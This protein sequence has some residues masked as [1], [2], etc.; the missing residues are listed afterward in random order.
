MNDKLEQLYNLYKQNGIIQSTDFNTFSSADENQKRKLY[1]LGKQ[2]GLFNTTDFNTFNSAFQPIKK[3]ETTVSP[4]VPKQK[5]ISSGTQPKVTQKPSATSVSQKE[6]KPEILFPAQKG[7]RNDIFTTQD[8]KTYRLDNSSG[9]P[10]WKGYTSSVVK[11]QGGSNQDYEVYDSAVTDPKTVNLLNQTFGKK[12]ST[13]EAE[14][15]FTGYTGKEENEYRIRNNVWQRKQKGQDDWTDLYSQGSISALNKEFGQKVK[16]DAARDKFSGASEDV[17]LKEK[18]YLDQNINSIN[19][20]LIGQEEEEVVNNLRKK[21]PRFTFNQEGTFT[22]ELKVQ[23]PNGEFTTISLDNFTDN[24]DNAQA[25]KLRGFIRTNSSK[26]LASATSSLEETEKENE[27]KSGI[28]INMRKAKPGDREYISGVA[29]NMQPFVQDVSF[30]SKEEKYKTETAEKVARK[31]YAKQTSLVFADVY[32]RQKQSLKEGSRINDKEV[33]AELAALPKSNDAIR[34]ANEYANDVNKSFKSYN[35]KIEELSKFS[36]DINQKLQSGEI[37]EEEFNQVYKPQ[38]ETMSN[39]IKTTG[40]NLKIDAT[41]LTNVDRAVNESVASQYIIDESQGSFGGG[42]AYKFVKGLTYIPRLIS[43]EMDAKGQEELVR[44]IVGGGT[45]K[46]YMESEDRNDIAKT[47][48]SLSESMGALASGAALGGGA[49]TY[50]AFY[51]QSYYEMKDELDQVEGMSDVSKVLMSAGYGALSSVLEK[52]GIDFA[53]QKTGVGKNLTNSIMKAVY[54]DLPKNASKEFIEASIVNNAKMFLRQAG[55]KTIGSGA[56]EGATEGLQALTQVGIKEVYDLAAKTDYFNNKSGWEI[57]GDIAYESYLGALGGGIMGTVSQGKSVIDRG[58]NVA[59]N[60]NQINILFNSA[61]IDGIPEALLTNLKSSIISGKVSQKEAQEIY[62][63]Y[64]E[65]KSKIQSI[66]EEY[67]IDNKSVALD[68]MLEK[69]RINKQI[70]GKDANLVK[71]QTDR[72]AE[73][74]NQLKT[75]GENAI[76][77]S[78]IEEVTAEGGGLQR[79][80]AQEGQPQ[81]GEGEGAVGET[82]QPETDLGNRP[83]EGRGIQELGE[84]ATQ[85]VNTYIAELGAN[86]RI[87]GTVDSVIT[88]MNNAEYINDSEINSTIDTI[89]NEVESI[90]NDA[91]YSD[92]TKK[93]L[94]DKLMNIAEQLDNYEF[95][96]KTETVAVTQRGTAPSVRKAPTTKVNAEKFFEG[97]TAEV[98]GVTATFKSNKGRTEAVMDNGETVVL[99]TPTMIINEGDFEFDDA[100]ALTAVTVTD[101]FG[102]TAKF[103][104]DIA[105]DLAIKQRENQIGTVEQAEFDTVYKDVETNYIKAKAPSVEVEAKKETTA[106]EV[107]AKETV[108]PTEPTVD[109]DAEVSKLED[110]L[111]RDDPNFQLDSEITQEEKKEELVSKAMDKMSES[112]INEMSEEAFEA[113]FPTPDVK[114]YPIE[115]KENSELANKLKRM[116]LKDLIGKKI[117]LVMADQLKVGEVMGRKRMGGPFFPL[118]DKLFGKVAWASMNEDAANKIINGAVKSDYTVVYNMSTTAIDSNVALTETFEDLTQSLPKNK[119]KEIFS[120]IQEQVLKNQYGKKTDQVRSIAKSSK[121]LNDFFTELDK[122]DVDTISAVVK[123]IMPSRDVDAATRIGK[124]LQDEGITIETVRE[125][126]I[127]QFASNLPTGALL[128]VIEVTD[129]SGKKVTKETAREALITPEQQDKEGLPKHNNYPIYVRGKAVALLNETV[130][131]WNMLKGSINNINVKVAGI[132]REKSG[133]RLTSKEALSNE[134]RSASMTAMV[135]K[136]V[137]DKINTQ[138]NRFVSAISKSFPNVEVVASQEEFDALLRDLNTKKLSTKNAKVYGAVY[139]GKLYLNPSL[140]NYNTPVHEFGHIW[141]NTAKVAS[142]KL[143]D[144]GISL[145]KGS[146]YENNVRDNKEYQRVIK[147]M[148]ADGASDIDIDN[149]IYEEALATAIGDKG[150][151]FVT[152][153]QRLEFN[154]W[155]KK[156]FSFVK[157]MTGISKYNA[158]QLEDITLDEFVQAVSVDIMSGT[159]L[160]KGAKTNLS[161]A[162]QLMTNGS[163]S[164]EYI[165]SV[166]RDNGISDAAIRK[167]LSNKGF[168][169]QDIKDAFKKQPKAP[170]VSKILGKP[171]PKKVIVNEAVALRD[172]LRLEA[173]AARESVMDLKR[174]Q[175]ALVSVVNGMKRNGSINVNQ[176]TA[177][178]KRIVN[179]NLDNPVMVDR[180]LNYAERLFKRADYQEVLKNAFG[181]RNKIRKAGKSKD[182]LQAEVAGMAKKFTKID[183]SL[184]EDIDM[185][186]E[187]AEKVYNAVR[188]VR[189]IKTGLVTKIAADIA[190]I[191]EYQTEEIKRQEEIL[192]NE[193]MN[194]HKYLVDSG[195]ITSEMSLKEIKDVITI[196]ENNPEADVT[197]RESIIRDYV[198]KAF[199]FYSEIIIDMVKTGVDPM[200]GEEISFDE[201]QKDIVKRLIGIDTDFMKLEDAYKS[202]EALDNFIVNKI[203]SGVEAIVNSYEGKLNAEAMERSGIKTRSLKLF[204]SGLGGRFFAEYFASLPVLIDT[205]FA[206]INAGQRFM[207]LS[208]LNEFANGVAKATREQNNMINEYGQKFEKSR[209]N[210][211]DFRAAENVYERGIIAYLSRTIDG[212]TTQQREELGRRINIVKDSI[213]ALSKGDKDQRKMSEIYQSLYDKLGLDEFNKNNDNLTISDIQSRADKTNLEAT[214]WW[215]GKWAEKYSDLADVSLSVYNTELGSDI[216][217][218]P[219]RYSKVEGEESPI[220]DVNL[221]KAG[222]FGMDLN[223][224]DKNKTGVLMETTRPR[225]TPG[226]YV[227]LD[228]DISNARSMK[229]ALVDINT[230]ASV[231]KID[232]FLRSPS[233]NKIIEDTKD[234][235]I[236]Q[237][238][239]NSYIRR[240]KHKAVINDATLR[241][242][243]SA[244]NYVASIG[245]VKALGGIFQPIK[246]TM[247]VMVNTIINAGP[248]NMS[249]ASVLGDSD[250]HEWIN[251]SGMAIANRGMEASTTVET[252]NKYLD[253]V[254]G[255]KGEALGKGLMKINEFWLKKFLQ[256]PDVWIAR[257]SFISY[258][259]QALRRKGVDVSKIDWKNHPVDKEAANYAQHMVDRQQNVSDAA[260]MGE[261]MASESGTWKIARKTLLPFANFIM[262]QK[263]RMY[264]D[265]RTAASSE[266]SKEDKVAALR[267]LSGLTI[268]LAAYQYIGYSIGVMI[269]S[270]AANLVGYE[271][272]DE[273]EEKNKKYAVQN[274]SNQYIKDVLSPLPLTDGAT[275]KAFDFIAD[276]IQDLMISD[277]EIKDAIDDENKVREEMGDDPMTD[278]QKEKLK[279][280]LINNRKYKFEDYKNDKL[281]N[282]GTLSI[283]LDKS[284]E[285]WEMT[286]IAKTGKFTE[287]SYGAEKTKYINKA[288]QKMMAY[289]SALKFASL[290]G[291]LPVEA[292]NLA[293]YSTKYI[294]KKAM[295]ENQKDMSTELMKEMNIKELKDYQVALIEKNKSVDSVIEEVD[296]VER[297]GGLKNKKQQEEYIKILNKN[298]EV[299]SEDLD[300]IQKLK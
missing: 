78:N 146:D 129:K 293:M 57:L 295:T 80:G 216:N 144:K 12:S 45:T 251:N 297:N 278:K 296:W 220:E 270:L 86:E 6:S 39:D 284:S 49:A 210:G 277:Q 274:A 198:K 280:D 19:S 7:K 267:S 294:K 254:A 104:G 223:F 166:A 227:N 63:S 222:A 83:V 10:I 276:Q 66:P 1:D 68:L 105:M 167:Y 262:N 207:N 62:N 249:L 197:D 257:S 119:Q 236:L 175:R 178:A 219:D 71:P 134:M 232:G 145:V 137:S 50:A 82:A 292:N 88:K 238:R 96:T 151:S 87:G 161:D 188:P 23:A 290:S 37:S 115:V 27:I 59:L 84:E 142:K 136:T 121:T 153:S 171:A 215:I 264:S 268:E 79:E 113:E 259:K 180:M 133:R 114:T 33:V 102:T 24:D 212:N 148:K 169:E 242:L 170:S 81:V 224:T 168:S 203:T 271:P 298:G 261:I 51:G 25:Q 16:Y 110:L 195:A 192:K 150:E 164:I 55:I 41:N 106:T 107:A 213:E 93:A 225:K 72:I 3:K 42:I 11:G 281:F 269:K 272:D 162:L 52:F 127:E 92:Q 47:L 201:K 108:A 70:A 234:K 194:M 291:A 35:S 15:V 183:P 77:E 191:A 21:F 189:L 128:M 256:Q 157:S 159:E 158:E 141:I 163:N 209:P 43:P 263:S 54:S 95:R 230:A 53:M 184:V 139:K 61:K 200:T 202:I 247:P 187:M 69:D 131:F 8:G 2:K 282:L 44:T 13:S 90:N 228:F 154:N 288:D 46:D 20:K 240:S 75:I 193:A 140:E 237:R 208:G 186:M 243:D 246:Q 126:N 205:M 111:K 156:L 118:I 132:V 123:N 214:N 181:L 30:V 235:Q 101:R 179:T 300:K 217:Y 221:Q 233:M 172:Q 18:K 48:F 65:V 286:K 94:S 14:Q 38:I 266:A 176:A 56:V 98:N 120:A 76:K 91:N 283:A 211:M 289:L 252:A 147:Q 116:G 138:Y 152:A 74:D 190:Q 22:D 279:E 160:F 260:M 28:N 275:L 109:I 29:E 231:R 143:Y 40:E 250:M 34:R 239:I 229:A 245:A 26:E 5:A 185:Y 31:E 299:T 60:K 85:E 155:M 226:R 177:L 4:S 206:G 199:D 67:S 149:Y 64:N 173:R 285:L 32:D 196:L 89:F 258:Y 100:G 73:I 130:P 287:E 124:L 204:F 265:F 174:K 36:N 117:N 182:K 255:S 97:Q 244:F 253:K 241:E 99:D 165:M 218:T 9:V 122:L 248:Q 125:M 135:A 103:T 112:D 17:Q 273:E 58:I